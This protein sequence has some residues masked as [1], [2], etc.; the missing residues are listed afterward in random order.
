MQYHLIKGFVFFS[1]IMKNSLVLFRKAVNESADLQEKIRGGADLV[2][3][4]KENGYSFTV[5]DINEA[6]EEL[7]NSDDERTE[8]ELEQVA[9]GGGDM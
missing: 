8:F 1:N 7:Q 2:A 5:K 4:G 6:Y 9:G 3:L